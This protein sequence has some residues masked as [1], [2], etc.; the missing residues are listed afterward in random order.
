[1]EKIKNSYFSYF[2]M[3]NFYYLSWALFSALISVYLI[4]KG[5][6]TS[7]VSLVVSMSFL[8]S[9]IAQ[10]F[11]GMLCDKY[12]VKKVNVVL[13][14]FAAIGGLLFA[15][16]NS[17]ITMMI[18]YSFVLTLLNGTN[19]AMEKMA[20]ASPFQYGKIRIWG[21]IGYAIGSQIAGLIYEYV[22][23][24]AI[25]FVFAI[26]MILCIIGT[27]LTN[28]DMPVHYK[29]V[30][31]N[32]SIKDLLGNKMYLYFLLISGIFYAATNM[33]NT[34][35]PSMF[36]HDGMQVGFASTIL[37]IAV[38]CEL[39][40][41]LFSNLFMDKIH[42]K[43]LLI[44]AYVMVCIQFAVYSFD[45]PLSLKVIATLIAKHP[46]GMLFI[47]IN[48][49]VVHTIVDEHQVITALAFVA[50][51]KNLVSIVSQNVAGVL[52]EYVSYSQM[53]MVF[54]IL[55]VIGLI[56]T[57]LYKV[58]KGDKVRLFS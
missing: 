38:F 34:Y 58:D 15:F 25:F 41:V 51:I 33:A 12:D 7:E 43:T 3:I 6:K 26:T 36:V 28:P 5:M 47:M 30:A 56:L 20:T 19:P 42:N 53:F 35:I 29:A 18:G 16:A 21:T 9:M 24:E 14:A 23:P 2:L 39:P 50:T 54:L 32:S 55:L 44:I 4:G 45:L 17:F 52:L 37:S 46:A 22:S 10:P 40:F 48:L 11:I 13:F 1:M 27:C 57:L 8:V 49:K 31:G